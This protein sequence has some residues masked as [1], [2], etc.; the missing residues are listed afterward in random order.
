MQRS[1]AYAVPLDDRGVAAFVESIDFCQSARPSP[2]LSDHF[3]T[4]T[5]GNSQTLAVLSPQHDAACYTGR[6]AIQKNSEPTAAR[7]AM[8]VKPA[9]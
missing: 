7:A 5:L 2:G 3:V 4:I 8:S 6:L 9:R 1:S